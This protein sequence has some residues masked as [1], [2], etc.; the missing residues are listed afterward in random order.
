MKKTLAIFLSVLM[1]AT[2]IVPSFVYADGTLTLELSADKTTVQRGDSITVTVTA[3]ENPGWRMFG[4]RIDYP[5]DAFAQN[6][7]VTYSGIGTG[8]KGKNPTIDS[9]DEDTTETGEYFTFTLVVK[10]DAPFGDYTIGLKKFD[11][12]DGEEE[13]VAT[14]ANT[15]S[16][17]VSDCLHDG[18]TTLHEAVASTCK[19]PGHAA[20]ITCDLCNA[21]IEGDAADLPLDPDNHEGEPENVDAV[22]ATCVTK[23]VTAGTK[24]PGCNAILSGCVVGELDPANHEGGDEAVDAVAA[25]CTTAGHEAGVKCTAC[26]EYKEG[27]AEIPVDANAHAWG[28]VTYTWS[29]DNTTCTATRVCANDPSH[30]ETET[31]NSN[32]SEKTPAGCTT[33]GTTTYTATFENTAFTEQSKDVDDIEAAGHTWGDV[34]YTWA[35]DNS[36]CTATRVCSKDETHVETET[37]N[38]SSDV[39]T[40]ATCTEKGTTTYTATFTNE[41]FETQTKDVEDIAATG[42]TYGEVTYTWTF[43]DISGEV[44]KEITEAEAA[45]LPEGAKI[46]GCYGSQTCANCTEN[47]DGHVVS[48][49]ANVT[50][51]VT[52]PATCTEKG[53]TTYT[54]TFTIDGFETQTLTQADVP[55][56]GHAWGEAT[57]TWSEDNATCTATRVCSKDETHV[58]TESSA[59]T[60]VVDPAATCESAGT[61]TYTATF[62]NEAFETQTKVVEGTPAEKG[63]AWGEPTYVW[64]EDGA[65]CTA[66]RVCA[67]DETHVETET[68]TATS[69]VTKT[70]TTTEKGETTYTATFT[71]EGFTAQTRTEEIPVLE[72]YEVEETEGDKD[73]SHTNGTDKDMTLTVVEPEGE[74]DPT[75]LTVTDEEGEEVEITEDDYTYEDGVFTLKESFFNRVGAGEYTISFQVGDK[76]VSETFEVKP[77]DTTTT[78]DNTA[79]LILWSMI[80]L[81]S[82]AGVVVTGTKIKKSTAR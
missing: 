63:H 38:S 76:G 70:A 53:V 28:E 64:S 60:A 56:T 52:T 8:T 23:G 43:W 12:I 59:A 3:T 62:A 5:T 25:T 30:V 1:L 55:A 67:N 44:Y 27:G 61:T 33:A 21:V 49:Y 77:A 2:L 13:D 36:T 22:T 80:A 18:A 7:N 72:A 82:L 71:K 35:E 47:T 15:I 24:C 17:T 10:D 81:V 6:D 50:S 31:V 66:T 39:K 16:I 74:F 46:I 54:A 9:G 69:E 29:D 73:L 48:E 34:T 42:H 51:E 19:T 68:V 57:Y 26:G 45:E 79:S 40:P 14:T 75:T 20:Y 37:V 65:S 78:G 4:A 41:A 11:V 58:E 32:S